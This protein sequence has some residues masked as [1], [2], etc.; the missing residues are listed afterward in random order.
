MRW[1]VAALNPPVATATVG[2]SVWW[3]LIYSPIWQSVMWR[4]GELQFL[5]GV[6]NPRP[7]RLTATAGKYQQH[8]KVEHVHVHQGGQA[9]VGAV[10]PGGGTRGNPRRSQWANSATL[11]QQPV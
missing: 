10:T 1:A 5:I 4:P 6:K 2:V 8:V 7:I 11:F 3:S 9:I